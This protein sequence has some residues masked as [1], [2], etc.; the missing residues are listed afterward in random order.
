MRGIRLVVLAA[1]SVAMVFASSV[2]KASGSGTIDGTITF[3]GA[4]V[5]PTCSAVVT[6]GDVNLI[7]SAA[8]IRPSLQRNCAGS[9]VMAATAG[10]S[11]PYAV[12]VVHLSGSEPDRVLKY[13]AD[14]VRAAQPSSANPVLVT[15]TYE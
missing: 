10:A 11:R 15:Q 14:Y 9:T 2:V 1:C 7:I 6:P 8:Q 3:V 4:V 12:D 5:E 13:F